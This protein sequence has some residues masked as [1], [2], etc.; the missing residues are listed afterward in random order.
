MLCNKL[1]M[2]SVL[3]L[4]MIFAVLYKILPSLNVPAEL[5]AVIDCGRA[6]VHIRERSPRHTLLRMLV[7]IVIFEDEVELQSHP[8][9]PR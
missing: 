1:Q 3:G 5:V 4:H 2:L 7:S 6:R 9:V 8:T